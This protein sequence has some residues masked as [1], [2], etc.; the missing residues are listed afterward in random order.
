MLKDKSVKHVKN[1]H[2]KMLFLG[3]IAGSL[4][5]AG[6]T[7]FLTQ[8]GGKH[9]RNQVYDT[10]NSFSEKANELKDNFLNNTSH[11]K[12]AETHKFN[13][14]IGGITGALIGAAAIAYFTNKNNSEAFLKHS[15]GFI[16]ENLK[17]K[18]GYWVKQ[19]KNII[20]TVDHVLD[21]DESTE[22][23]TSSQSN[24]VDDLVELANV[25]MRLFQSY[26]QRS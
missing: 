12:S 9:Y 7:F 2:S 24:M 6:L 18:T 14:V 22:E 4:L 23:S 20:N 25:G 1:E 17:S 26:K 10:Y 3:T 11:S 21:E 5:G 8:K 16:P 15:A 13:L 19:A